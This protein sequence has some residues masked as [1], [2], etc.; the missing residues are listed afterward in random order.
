MQIS[1]VV[2]AS[3]QNYTFAYSTRIAEHSRQTSG[4]TAFQ[5]LTA[6]S[7]KSSIAQKGEF[8]ATGM[9]RNGTAA[10]QQRR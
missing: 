8:K 6:T 1:K 7:T 9:A 2:C 10:T 5:K 3:A 4:G